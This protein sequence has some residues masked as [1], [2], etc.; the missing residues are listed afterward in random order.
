MGDE[1][2]LAISDPCRDEKRLSEKM[3]LFMEEASGKMLASGDLGE[4]L[5]LRIL[6]GR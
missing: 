4:S 6:D 1:N 2:V 5:K 3:S